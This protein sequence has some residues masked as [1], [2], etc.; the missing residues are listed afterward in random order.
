MHIAFLMAAAKYVRAENVHFFLCAQNICAKN[1]GCQSQLSFSSNRAF[2]VVEEI[3][4]YLQSSKL[5][6]LHIFY[7][8]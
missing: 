8:F 6:F 5:V 4:Y 1:L 3:V 7:I 2:H